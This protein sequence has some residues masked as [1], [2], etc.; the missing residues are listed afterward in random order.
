MDIT[1]LTASSSS[2]QLL[3]SV[4]FLFWF[5]VSF[6]L[7]T[8]KGRNGEITKLLGN[9]T[10][11][12]V[13]EYR[14]CSETMEEYVSVCQNQK[15]L[16]ELSI[17]RQLLSMGQDSNSTAPTGIHSYLQTR[18]RAPSTIARF[19]KSAS[20]LNDRGTC[21][22][23]IKIWSSWFRGHCGT[24]SFN[25]PRSCWEADGRRSCQ[26]V[27]KLSA[28]LQK[29]IERREWWTRQR[30]LGRRPIDIFSDFMIFNYLYDLNE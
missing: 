11:K 26:A 8:E 7:E 15:K 20:R 14:I 6:F 21:F 18:N 10:R 16:R 23:C 12:R 2:Q 29:P 25:W 27:W 22:T 17:Q 30:E 19:S 5:W 1:S 13:I 4:S 24:S 3:L 28:S 9:R